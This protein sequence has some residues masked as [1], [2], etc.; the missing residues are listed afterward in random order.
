[1]GGFAV[2]YCSES[3]IE[4]FF[5]LA[6]TIAKFF[7]LSWIVNLVQSKNLARA[8]FLIHR[9]NLSQVMDKQVFDQSSEENS[10]ASSQDSL[11]EKSTLKQQLVSIPDTNLVNTE[12]TVNDI[13]LL[14]YHILCAFLAHFIVK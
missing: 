10:Q 14:F 3:R 12:Y 11:F 4:L 2:V 13:I 9:Y 7:E 5:I 1:M 6:M 8:I